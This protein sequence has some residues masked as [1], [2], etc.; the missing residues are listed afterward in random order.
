VSLKLTRL[1]REALK[2]KKRIS[3]TVTATFLIPHAHPVI[4]TG[5]LVLAS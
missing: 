4:W 2:G 3:L 1:G 5:T